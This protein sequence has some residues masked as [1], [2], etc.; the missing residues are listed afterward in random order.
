M[1]RQPRSRSDHIADRP[2]LTRA[3]LLL[4][5]VQSAAVMAVFFGWY[6]THGYWGQFLDLP[7]EGAIYHQAVSMALATVIFTQIG[8]LFAQRADSSSFRRVGWFT[9]RLVWAGI[10][11]ELAIIAL[12][13]YVPFLQR[14]F[15][16]GSIPLS[17][18]LWIVP[19]IPLIPLAD[20]IRKAVGR[21]IRPIEREVVAV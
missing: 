11:S 1:D 18:W 20:G 14:I 10:A 15:D 17:A 19:L 16:T 13:V 4:G 8:N 6:W 5:A 12:I 3:F 9:N 21:R 7:D 2:L